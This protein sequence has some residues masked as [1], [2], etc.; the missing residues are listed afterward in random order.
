MTVDAETRRFPCTPASA[1]HVRAWLRESLTAEA[2]GVYTVDVVELLASEVVTN[3]VTHTVSTGL[4][5]TMTV[6]TVV[7]VAVQ[8]ESPRGPAIGQSD[9]LETG[10]RGLLLVQALALAWGTHRTGPERPCGSASP[11]EARTRRRRGRHPPAA[12]HRAA[13][14]SRSRT[15]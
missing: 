6:G 9:L 1:Q 15:A 12:D 7:E 5:V 2:F 14:A 3:A 10:G 4:L 8:D 11:C 13:I